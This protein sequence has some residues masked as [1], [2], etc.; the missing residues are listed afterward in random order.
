[1]RSGHLPKPPPTYS[2]SRGLSVHC[3]LITPPPRCSLIPV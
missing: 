3:H 2:C 1:M